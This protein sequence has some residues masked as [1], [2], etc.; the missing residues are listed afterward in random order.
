MIFGYKT[1]DLALWSVLYCHRLTQKIKHA[2][3]LLM[4]KETHKL[5]MCKLADKI[6]VNGLSNMLPGFVI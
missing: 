6:L 4:R 5:W 1:I 2:N 3:I